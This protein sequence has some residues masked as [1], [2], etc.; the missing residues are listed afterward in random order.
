MVVRVPSFP[1]AFQI[2]GDPFA[3]VQGVVVAGVFWHLNWRGWR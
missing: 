1:T 2:T 3:A